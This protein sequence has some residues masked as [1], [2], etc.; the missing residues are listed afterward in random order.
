MHSFG[1][2]EGVLMG[3]VIN[4]FLAY[5]ILELIQRTSYPLNYLCFLF[6][7]VPPYNTFLLTDGLSLI[8]S[9]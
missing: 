3:S 5:L 1:Y 4:I 2:V 6:Q 8:P 9:R 7:A